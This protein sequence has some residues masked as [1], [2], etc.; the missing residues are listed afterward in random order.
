MTTSP[1]SFAV[2]RLSF[3]ILRGKDFHDAADLNVLLFILVFQMDTLA[4]NTNHQC[5]TDAD[6][7]QIITRARTAS[8]K[9]RSIALHV[10]D[11]RL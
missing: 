10:T 3:L 9:N 8:K 6:S 4:Q 11:Q 5:R 2:R 7:Q 1:A